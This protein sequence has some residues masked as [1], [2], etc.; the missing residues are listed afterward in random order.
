MPNVHSGQGAASNTLSCARLFPGHCKRG[1]N[2]VCAAYNDQWPTCQLVAVVDAQSSAG[3][4]SSVCE[5]DVNGINEE[6]HG[7]WG[8]Y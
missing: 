8:G 6:S 3:A 1:P 7:R 4:D 5:D 2:Y